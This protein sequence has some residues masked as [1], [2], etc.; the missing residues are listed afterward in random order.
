MANFASIA[1]QSPFNN[2][3]LPGQKSFYMSVAGLAALNPYYGR[4]ASAANNSVNDEIPLV[5]A[6]FFTLWL[7]TYDILGYAIGG[8]NDPANPLTPVATFAGSLQGTLSALTANGAK[9]AVANIPDVI[10][11]PFFNTI[12]YNVL[13]IPDQ[14][15]A[16]ALNAG[17]AGLNLLI[18]SL[19]SDDTIHFEVGPNPIIIQDAALPWGRRHILS[20]ELVLLSLPQDS[21]KCAGWGSQKPVPANFILD[22]AEISNIQTAVDEYNDQVSQLISGK[23]IALVDMYTAMKE[24]DAGLTFEGVKVNSAFVTGNF[25]STDG[26]NPAFRGNAVIA[27]YF[28]EAI[29]AKFGANIPQVIVSDFPGVTLP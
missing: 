3:G 24:V 26:L 12:P 22:V 23:D 8:G 9:G 13:N 1:A 17:Y 7:G 27:H 21:L 10:E 18:I 11:A 6:T 4:F 28:I 25:Y 2:I 29:N 15:T 14:A 19:E 16:D 5:N 20:S